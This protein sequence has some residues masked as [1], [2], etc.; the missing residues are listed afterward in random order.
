MNF[1][2]ERVV[3]NKPGDHLSE[4][5]ICANFYMDAMVHAKGKRV[6]DAACGTGFGSF[7]LSRV[8]EELFSIDVEPEV[9]EPHEDILPLG[10][11]TTK[12]ALNLETE[13]VDITADLCVSIET[14][15]HLANPDFFLSNLKAKSLFFTIPCY[16]D[17]NNHFHK[18]EYSEESAKAL[19]TKYFPILEYRMEKKRM[20]G[21]AHKPLT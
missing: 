9:F 8:A 15:E 1:T 21:I 4:F 12:L 19:I 20:I 3:W 6:I 10:C 17:K 13:P 16:G 7:L 5:K 18:I 2:G 11:K 14:I